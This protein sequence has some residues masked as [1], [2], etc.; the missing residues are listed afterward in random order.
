MPF[1]RTTGDRPGKETGTAALRRRVAELSAR[2]EESE[3]TL[4]AIRGGE[5]DAV[6][7]SG[8]AGDRVFTLEGADR[9][10]RVFLDDM[11]DGAVSLAK[12]GLILYA[13][14]RFAEIVGAPLEKVIGSMIFGFMSPSDG[15]ALRGSLATANS[16]GTRGEASFETPRGRV[17]ALLSLNALPDSDPPAICMVVTDLTERARIYQELLN[18]HRE[19]AESERRFRF[20]VD[21]SLVGFFI[22]AGGRIVFA[23]AEQQRIFGG[24]ELPASVRDLQNVLPQDRERFERLCDESSVASSG[25]VETDIR[26]CTER[27]AEDNKGPLWA[28]CRAAP[29]EYRRK[30]AVLVNMV[31]VTRTREIEQIAILQEKMASLGQV[32][33]GIAHNIRN[34]LSGMNMYLSTMKSLLD[35]AP[36]MDARTKEATD[37]II[38]MLLQASGKIASVIRQVLDFAKPTPP[39]MTLVQVGNAI[40]EAVELCRVHMNRNGVS[41]K[42]TIPEGLPACYAGAG[43]LEQVFINVI[44]NATQALQNHPGDRSIAIDSDATDGSVVVRISDSG[45]GVPEKIREKIFEPFYTTRGQGTGIGLAFSRRV[46]DSV[47]GRIDVGRGTLGGAEFLI[48]IP[49]GD[50]RKSPRVR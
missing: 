4:S 46:M 44:N 42:V 24:L 17:P 16:V 35:E 12:D 31:D 33:A 38:E 3:A 41:I 7:V 21:S 6:L 43:L 32:T 10:Y 18:A 8:P 50:R 49:A 20:L 27:T 48:R 13:N 45:P 19:V 23:N 47:G 26:F 40:R 9:T 2:L 5:V 36:G 28:H 1:G 34:P 30:I 37:R 29:I 14:R 15:D 22:A 25:M 11:G 39:A